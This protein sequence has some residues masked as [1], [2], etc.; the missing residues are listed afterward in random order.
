L[1][2][3]QV[4]KQRGQER[5][6]SNMRKSS[7]GFLW[8]RAAKIAQQGNILNNGNCGKIERFVQNLTVKFAVFAF[9]KFAMRPIN[10]AAHTLLN[11]VNGKFNTNPL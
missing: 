2:K 3:E 10:C 1:E 11:L 6:V 5:R 7:G 9:Q 8:I 4:K